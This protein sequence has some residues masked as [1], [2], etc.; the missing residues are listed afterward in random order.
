MLRPVI[1][2]PVN[3]SYPLGNTPAVCLT[4]D[5]PPGTS[6]DVLLLGCG[7]ARNVLF[8]IYSEL[9]SAKKFTFACCDIQA[10]TIARNILL[11]TLILEYAEETNIETIWKIY[12]DL[13]L[14]DESSRLLETHVQILLS[15]SE[16]LGSWKN[17]KYGNFI[18]FY[19]ETTFKQIKAI[20][21]SYAVGRL[22]ADQKRSYERAYRAGIRR[23]QDKRKQVI[24]DSDPMPLL[25]SVFPIFTP[26]AARAI[27]PLYEQYWR[28]GTTAGYTSDDLVPNPTFAPAVLEPLTLHYG[29]HPLAGFHLATASAPLAPGSPLRSSEPHNSTMSKATLAA[30]EEFREWANS[31]RLSVRQNMANLYFVASD[32]ISFCHTLQNMTKNGGNNISA[33]WYRDSWH[34]DPLILNGGNGRQERGP[35]VFD[36]I[37]TSNLSDHI[38]PLNVL[39]SAAPLLKRRSTST[40]Y[41]ELL[42][43]KD[44]DFQKLIEN[45]LCGDC[46]AMSVLLGLFPVE[47][48][49]NASL[50]STFPDTVLQ[51]L[52]NP[53][54]SGNSQG[55][56]RNRIAWKRSVFST[57][58]LST[59]HAYKV[60]FDESL[61][62]D[63]I[64]N[65]ASE[66]FKHEDIHESLTLTSE[67]LRNITFPCYT[68]ASVAALLGIVKSR[69][70]VDWTT[71]MSRFIE[72]LNSKNSRLG[73]HCLNEVL[74]SLYLCGIPTAE[75]L[76][77]PFDNM[78]RSHSSRGIS[79]W[80]DVPPVVA[81]TVRIPRAK[82]NALRD[83][84]EKTLIAPAL[85]VSVQSSGRSSTEFQQ[86][87]F[88]SIQLSFGEPA[89]SGTRE[90]DNFSLRFSEDPNGISG[91]SDM[92][93][94]FYIATSQILHGPET[95]T[96]ALRV[97]NTMIYAF[98]YAQFFGPDLKVFETDLESQDNIYISKFLPNQSG[99]P[100]VS[101]SADSLTQ[102]F[103]ANYDRM[104]LTADLQ[105]GH[106]KTLT[107]RVTI[108]M[109][110]IKSLLTNRGLVASTQQSACAIRITIGQGIDIGTYTLQFPTP[111]RLSLGKTR[112]ARKSG[113][114]EVEVPLVHPTEIDRFPDFMFPTDVEA[115]QPIIWNAPWLN[116]DR[117]PILDGSFIKE[118]SWINTIT[119]QMFSSSERS[120]REKSMTE[121]DTT[122]NDVRVDFKDSIFSMFMHFTGLQGHPARIFG[123]N[124]PLHGSGIN[125]LIFVSGIR[126]D[127]SNQ[128]VI[129]D[130]ALLPLTIDLVRKIAPTLGSLQDKGLCSITVDERE[131]QLWKTILPVFIERCRTHRH[132]PSC[133]Y[134]VSEQ[135]P[136]SVEPSKPFVCG[137]GRGE[138]P[139]NFIDGLPEWHVL[140]RYCVRAA[141]SPVFSVPYVD[142]PFDVSAYAPSVM[143]PERCNK[144]G[145]TNS[146]RG[147]SL[148]RCSRCRLVRYCSDECQKAD[149]KK[150]KSVCNAC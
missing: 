8:T 69:A 110:I 67:G 27:A 12:Y 16:S 144:C 148:L 125:M 82:V 113:Y 50:A 86:D 46:A 105:R 81:M 109:P 84:A 118:L 104:S 30:Q 114:V 85:I 124:L 63:V 17:G 79:N 59:L 143:S 123:I 132:R 128:N 96:V 42:V 147:G 35:I 149:W 13:F 116:L 36:V 112:V 9:K 6:A 129:L 19:D 44:A 76:K 51:M 111:V 4:Q 1:I 22:D 150:H 131:L 89:L 43:R 53:N 11:Y 130:S 71:F 142:K 20:W 61:L 92:F 140:S 37:D 122:R 45:L 7:D 25:R 101:A 100:S 120:L 28:N 68:R 33:N 103:S 31:F 60:G 75:I 97:M 55:Q 87:L 57:A 127:L 146:M 139:A 62:A 40:L 56:M 119:S 74:V 138:F 135:I 99:Y 47:Y 41:T 48:W 3:L 91:N 32:A 106:I 66:M 54:N 64:F 2:D 14:E 58:L 94:S 83:A 26:D 15:L 145:Q 39:L 21:G 126:I 95:K 115:G 88:Q 78:E 24:G 70:S 117:S 18:H 136:I 107:G 72:R 90:E 23:A 10:T 141:I 137:C 93:V 133:E 121:E 80:K 77:P 134:G 65:V 5:L 49:T 108:V 98:K 38:G 73:N 34:V 52:S 29:T 102:S